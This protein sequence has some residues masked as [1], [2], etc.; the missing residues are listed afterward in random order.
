MAQGSAQPGSVPQRSPLDQ[1]PDVGPQIAGASANFGKQRNG[2]FQV[3][4]CVIGSPLRVKQ[5]GEV[6]F[7]GSLV[8][9]VSLAL[10]QAEGVLGQ[11][12]RP[13]SVARVGAHEGKCVQGGNSHARI[14]PDSSCRP[15]IRQQR[16]GK[17]RRGD[18]PSQMIASGGQVTFAATDH[19]QQVLSPGDRH[20]ISRGV[21]KNERLGGQLRRSARVAVPVS[22]RTPIGQDL[23]SCP[24]ITARTECDQCGNKVSVGALAVPDAGQ[25][26]PKTVVKARLLL[27]TGQAQRGLEVGDGA[28]VVAEEGQNVA[29]CAMDIGDRW[30]S[31]RERGLEVLARLRVGEDRSSGSARLPM[32]IRGPIRPTGER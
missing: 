7:E 2:A 17:V 9:E 5:V 32:G 3:E 26:Q 8:V 19:P 4:H 22:N 13:V 23:S 14:N 16:F 21:A 28:V 1:R 10:A 18:R 24:G 29:K 6:V 12:N 27:R 31:K 25:D 20:G 30:M 15:V 11:L